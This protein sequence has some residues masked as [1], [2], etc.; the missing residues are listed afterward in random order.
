[1]VVF[2]DGPNDFLF[3]VEPTFMQQSQDEVLTP[4]GS[5]SG[6]LDIWHA[7]PAGE[8]AQMVFK[9]YLPAPKAASPDINAIDQTAINRLARNIVDMMEE[10]WPDRH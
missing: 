9:K 10:P 7:L 4:R 1:M 5:I 6:L 3:A 8:L 2:M